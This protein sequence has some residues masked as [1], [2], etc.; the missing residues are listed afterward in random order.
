MHYVIDGYNVTKRDPVTNGLSLE[1]QRDAL[2]RRLRI[3]ATDMLGK[4]TYLIVW[5]AAGGEGVVRPTDPHEEY[6]RLPTADDAI[7][8][9]VRRAQTRIG[10]VTSD[11][12][13]ADRCRSVASHGVDIL[14]A[15]RLFAAATSKA[16]S[17]RKAPLPRDIGIPAN[18]NEINRELKELWGID[19]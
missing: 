7:V 9:K 2:E 3:T 17:H 14:P 16:K 1:A 4:A 12:K 8:E 19:D 5:D 6:T 13:L 18:A 15:E 10:V 11:R